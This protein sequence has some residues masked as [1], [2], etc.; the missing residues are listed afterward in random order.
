MRYRVY[1][2]THLRSFFSQSSSS[3]KNVAIIRTL[4]LT[5]SKQPKRGHFVVEDTVIK[6]VCAFVIPVNNV[7]HHG[8]FTSSQIYRV[9][10]MKKEASMFQPQNSLHRCHVGEYSLNASAI[11]TAFLFFINICNAEIQVDSKTY[12]F[13]GS[14]SPCSGALR[15]FRTRFAILFCSGSRWLV[16]MAFTVFKGRYSKYTTLMNVLLQHFALSLCMAHRLAV[17]GY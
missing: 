17:L 7:E 2:N 14:R 11:Q 1:V 12:R 5:D 13:E 3:S 6:V 9:A 8:Q 15:T 16:T 10:C 4:D